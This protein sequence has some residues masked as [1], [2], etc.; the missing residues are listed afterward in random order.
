[1]WNA[2]DISITP[3]IMWNSHDIRITPYIMWK[4]GL[5][6]SARKYVWSEFSFAPPSSAA[7]VSI[8]KFHIGDDYRENL[9]LGEEQDS[10]KILTKIEI[11]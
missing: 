1:M 8:K 11:S 10:C 3:Y 9:S 4:F 6:D 5:S 2:Q 7:S